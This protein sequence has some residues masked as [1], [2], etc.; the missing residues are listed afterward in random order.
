MTSSLDVLKL[1]LAVKDVNPLFFTYL[2]TNTRRRRKWSF[3]ELLTW[4]NLA[5]YGGGSV[6]FV[7]A[8]IMLF[9]TVSTAIG[10][11]RSV[12][13]EEEMANYGLFD[14]IPIRR[15]DSNGKVKGQTKKEWDDGDND[16]V[17]KEWKDPNGGK[18]IIMDA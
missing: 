12:E 15:L 17:D 8:V 2:S 6:L 7:L 16:N 4:P 3:R 1:Q 18:Y 10:T 13:E 11:T 9:W 14:G 5:R